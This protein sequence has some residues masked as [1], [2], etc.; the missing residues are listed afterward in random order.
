MQKSSIL[1]T[2]WKAIVYLKILYILKIKI[3]ENL[4][5]DSTITSAS[6]NTRKSQK[7]CNQNSKFFKTMKMCNLINL[8]RRNRTC[9]LTKNSPHMWVWVFLHLLV[10]YIRHHKQ[11]YD[12][13]YFLKKESVFIYFSFSFSMII[14][15]TRHKSI[16][17]DK[18]L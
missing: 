4:S 8:S 16:F 6:I 11:N 14:F 1:S 7:R 9:S 17:H 3:A 18:I 5:F 12:Q 15:T 2:F 10:Y 13:C